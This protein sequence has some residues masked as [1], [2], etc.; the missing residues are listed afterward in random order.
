[1]LELPP[2]KF[3]TLLRQLR[4]PLCCGGWLL[5]V[6]AAVALWA[7]NAAWA[8]PFGF[9]LG[10]VPRRDI[11][12]AVL[13]TEPNPAATEDARQKAREVARYVYEQNAEPLVQLRAALRNAVVAVT[14]ATTYEALDQAAWRHF[15][16]PM[17]EGAA[18]MARELEE[19]QFEQFRAALAEDKELVKFQQALAA[20]LSTFESRGLLEKLPPEHTGGN[21]Q[22]ILV[23]QAKEAKPLQLVRIEDVLIGAVSAENGPLQQRLTQ[24][25]ES[26]DLAGAGLQLAAAAAGEHVEAGPRRH[27][28][29][30]RTSGRG[31]ARGESPAIRWATCWPR[32]AI[33]WTKAS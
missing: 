31:G 24:Q 33:L 30:A 29:R 3:F 18:P 2:G 16:A 28:R 14:S 7:V 11:Q 6:L 22:E 5:A 12:A 21:Q 15:Q 23:H 17:P 8:P 19:Q 27:G 10:D 4:S 26:K 32:P 20:A 25:F 9:R 1:M 13:F